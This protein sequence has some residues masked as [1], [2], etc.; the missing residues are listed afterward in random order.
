MQTIKFEIKLRRKDGSDTYFEYVTLDDLLNKK[1]FLFNPDI[2]EIVYARQ[3]IGVFAKDSKEIYVGDILVDDNNPKL[4]KWL[5]VFNDGAY[6][7]KN[8][9][10]DGNILP[11]AFRINQGYVSNRIILGNIFE[12]HGELKFVINEN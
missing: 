11:D 1:N 5:V 4:F 10:D 12:T 2:E 9:D 6:S 7:I 8:I 3:F